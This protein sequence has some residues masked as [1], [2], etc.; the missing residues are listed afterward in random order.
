MTAGA[1]RRRPRVVL[2]TGEPGSGKT[3]LGLDAV[4]AV[5]G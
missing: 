5:A 3:G 2:L 4:I 1:G